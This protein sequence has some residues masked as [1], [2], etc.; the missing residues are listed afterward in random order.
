MQGQPGNLLLRQG[1]AVDH[2]LC[3]SPVKV[4]DGAPRIIERLIP[5]SDR[6]IAEADGAAV[7]LDRVRRHQLTVQEV[8]DPQVFLVDDRCQVKPPSEVGEKDVAT[9]EAVT[10]EKP[11]DVPKATP[12]KN[13]TTTDSVPKPVEKKAPTLNP[14]T[15]AWTPAPKPTTKPQPASS[16]WKTMA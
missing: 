2:Q 11:A 16:P 6:G 10:E 8:G 1:F 13:E 5:V 3:D 12:A 4:A 7:L 15:K 9:P 14:G